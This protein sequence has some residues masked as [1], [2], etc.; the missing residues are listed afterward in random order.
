MYLSTKEDICNREVETSMK[1]SHSISLSSSSSIPWPR[2]SLGHHRW[3]HNQF[4]PFFPVS[5]ALWDLANSRPVHSLMLL[6][7]LFFC[8]PCL[9]PP[10][11]VPLKMIL[12]R[13]DEWET[14]PYHFSLRLFTM[15]KRSLC[16][17]ISCWILAQASSLVTWSLHELHGVSCGSTSF[18]WL[19]FFFAA[20]LWGA[21][22]SSGRNP[23][24]AI[25]LLTKKSVFVQTS[26]VLRD[27]V[28]SF[29]IMPWSC[30]KWCKMCCQH[31]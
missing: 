29:R 12:A 25:Q 9:L 21:Q 18:P 3:F 4:P 7:H 28:L 11:T 6:S 22:M 27:V 15:V 14:S 1:R 24:G 2:G 30:F 10:F 20:L 19:K 16:G 31:C 26:T 8:L 17:L 23:K 13:P 5:T